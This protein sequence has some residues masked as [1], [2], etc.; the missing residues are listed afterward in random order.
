LAD[1]NENHD[2]RIFDFAQVL[3]CTARSLHARDPLGVDLGPD[4][5]TLWIQLLDN[6][7]PPSPKGRSSCCGGWMSNELWLKSLGR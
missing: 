4:P 7:T 1:A 6:H 2:W 3:I 5:V